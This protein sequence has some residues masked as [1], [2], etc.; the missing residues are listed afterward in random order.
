LATANHKPLCRVRSSLSRW[1]PVQRPFNGITNSRERRPIVSAYLMRRGPAFMSK[2]TP[3]M[4]TLPLRRFRSQDPVAKA[5]QDSYE[6]APHNPQ[7]AL[8]YLNVGPSSEAYY[9]SR[10][11]TQTDTFTPDPAA[12]IRAPG[13]QNTV[14]I[15]RGRAQGKK[16]VD[17]WPTGLLVKKRMAVEE[18]S[19][20][21]F[22]SS[23]HPLGL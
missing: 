13:I 17:F 2:K 22:C 3:A 5:R 21:C 6:P 23:A 14:N 4:L 11:G 8:A 15:D 10:K 16:R 1:E 18:S 9:S 19:Q 20:G 12:P 7:L